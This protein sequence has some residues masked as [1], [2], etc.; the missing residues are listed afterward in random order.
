[1]ARLL[2]DVPALPTEALDRLLQDLREEGSEHATLALIIARD[3][4]L[5]RPSNRFQALN[6]M[7]EMAVSHDDE[8][9]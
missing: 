9:R 1:M 3:M 8:L 4:T 2:L 7:L 6:A 5:M